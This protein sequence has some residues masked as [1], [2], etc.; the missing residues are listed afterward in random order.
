MTQALLDK[1]LLDHAM[2]EAVALPC[3]LV[4][5]L[6]SDVSVRQLSKGQHRPRNAELDRALVLAP[7]CR[8]RRQSRSSTHARWCP[9]PRACRRLL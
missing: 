9:M 6:N 8:R 2:I 3:W 5:G 1:I 7:G 4:L